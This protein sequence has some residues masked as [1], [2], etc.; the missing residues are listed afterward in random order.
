MRSF[1]ALSTTLG[2]IVLTT[3]RALLRALSEEKSSQC[4]KEL[5]KAIRRCATPPFD[6]FP[7]EI[8]RETIDIIHAEIQNVRDQVPNERLVRQRALF[9]ALSSALSAQGAT[10]ALAAT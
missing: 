7:Q 9:S 6:R 5:C 10:A 3:Q 2:D 4:A 1:S 8:L